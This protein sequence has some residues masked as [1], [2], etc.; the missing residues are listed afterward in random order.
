MSLNISLDVLE[1]FLSPQLQELQPNI[2]LQQGGSP[3]TWGF[4]VH[5]S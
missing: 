2:L 1:Q 4:I 5:D 3:P